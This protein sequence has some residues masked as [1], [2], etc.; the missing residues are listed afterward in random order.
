MIQPLAHSVQLR[1]PNH[2]LQKGV[3]T[4]WLILNCTVFF[5]SLPFLVIS[6]HSSGPSGWDLHS[7]V[8]DSDLNHVASDGN[9]DKLLLS[10]NYKDRIRFCSLLNLIHGTIIQNKGSDIKYAIKYFTKY[11]VGIT[12]ARK[13]KKK[14]A[15]CHKNIRI[16][17][18]QFLCLLFLTQVSVSN[19]LLQL[20]NS[21]LPLAVLGRLVCIQK[22]PYFSR[23]HS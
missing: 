15:K 16:C 20:S 18:K 9:S 4:S 23:H 6:V 12:A 13:K 3:V 10:V 21:T 8:L 19:R 5:R 22:Y 7:R 1:I 2:S 17:W 14:S 11:L